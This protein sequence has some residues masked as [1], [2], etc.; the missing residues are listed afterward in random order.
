MFVENN[1]ITL[2][3]SNAVIVVGTNKR[4]AYKVKGR[5][6]ERYFIIGFE[7]LQNIFGNLDSPVHV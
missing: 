7:M 2:Q 3:H 6:G 1:F 4:L 5:S